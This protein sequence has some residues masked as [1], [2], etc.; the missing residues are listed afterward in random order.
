MSK[1]KRLRIFAGPNGSGKSTLFEIFQRNFNPGIFINSDVIEKEILEKGFLDLQPF[2]LQL[3]QEDLLLFLQKPDTRSLIEKAERAGHRIEVEI[4]ENV[5]VDQSRDTHSYEASLVTSFIRENLLKNG[6]TFSFETVM[7]HPSKLYEIEEAKKLGYTVYLYF[8]CL[9]AAILN[10]SRVKNRV[11]KGGHDVDTEKIISR[12]TNTL[13]NL[14]PALKL[15]DKAYLF[16]NSNE[17]LLIAE[18]NDHMI[19]INIDETNFPNW[20]IENVINRA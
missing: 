17:M 5:I 12:Y 13:E 14:Y 20:F 7:S 6:I 18:K 19:T 16:D 10:I 8:I 4:K 3:Q 11:Q 9:D 15:V 2:G 1:I